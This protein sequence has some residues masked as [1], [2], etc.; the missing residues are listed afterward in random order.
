MLQSVC[1]SETVE[2]EISSSMGSIM[3]YKINARN[4]PIRLTI[5]NCPFIHKPHS[6]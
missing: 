1:M 4:V 2:L 3:K 5:E 6:E